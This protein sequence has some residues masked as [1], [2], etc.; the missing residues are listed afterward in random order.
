[1]A[2]WIGPSPDH[3]HI[4]DVL[5]A[6]QAWRDRCFLGGGSVFGDA[7]LWTPE[8]MTNLSGQL[9]VDPLDGEKAKF[10]EKLERQLEGARSEV[11][12]LAAEAVWFAYLF[13]WKGDMFP[14]TK[15]DRITRVWGWSGANA[16]DGNVYLSDRTL[17]G[18]GRAGFGYLTRLSAELRFL[19]RVVGEWQGLPSNR[20]TAPDGSRVGLGFRRL[21]R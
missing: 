18:V 19:M 17:S 13:V 6:A 1:M 3:D 9:E 5:A 2:R 4:R 12:Q 10:F 16:I 14:Q 15:R 7:S 8:N 21:A 11:V 20:R